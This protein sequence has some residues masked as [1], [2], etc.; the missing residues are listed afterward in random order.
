[1]MR[2]GLVFQ[3]AIA[4]LL[5]FRKLIRIGWL[6]YRNQNSLLFSRRLFVWI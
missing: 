6:A 4:N 1:V 3:D 5:K 2:T